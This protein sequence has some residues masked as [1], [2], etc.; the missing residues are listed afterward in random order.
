MIDAINEL[1]YSGSTKVS[2]KLANPGLTFT[3]EKVTQYTDGVTY[4]AVR[5]AHFGDYETPWSAPTSAYNDYAKIYPTTGVSTH[6]SP[7]TYGAS[8]AAAWLGRWGVVRNNWYKLSI[9]KINAV[10]SPVPVDFGGTGTGEP[11]T[12]P[13]D[14]PEK[15]YISAHV[16]IVPWVLR[17]QAVDLK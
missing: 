15:F 10:G 9:D 17:E 1:I 14:N 16:H 12:I 6:T 3:P 8:R 5:I 2:A 13:D 4:Y 7:I 11:G